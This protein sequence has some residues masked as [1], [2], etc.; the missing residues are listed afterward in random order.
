[1][2][3]RRVTAD[4]TVVPPDPLFQYQRVTAARKKKLKLKERNGS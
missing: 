3:G 2:Y 1:M 4:I